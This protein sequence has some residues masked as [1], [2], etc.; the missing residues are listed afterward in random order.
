MDECEYGRRA[1]GHALRAERHVGAGDVRAA[2]LHYG[3]AVAYAERAR[4]SRGSIGSLGAVERAERVARDVARA[5][6]ETVRR[7]VTPERV[8]KLAGLAVAG[9]VG[10]ALLRSS[11]SVGETGG[12]VETRRDGFWEAPRAYLAGG[13][14]RAA[15]LPGLENLG[16]T[17]FMNAAVQCVISVPALR[18]LLEEA[19]CTG[20]AGD[21]VA[22]VRELGRAEGTVV[23]R[24]FLSAM[25]AE[26]KRGKCADLA[27]EGAQSDPNEFLMLLFAVIN[28]CMPEF[29][30]LRL[31][32]KRLQLQFTCSVCK[33]AP[34][35]REEL[36]YEHVLPVLGRPATLAECVDAYNHAHEDEELG[37]Y[38]CEFCN[39]KN[40]TYRVKRKHEVLEWPDV[41]VLQLKRYTN[42][43]QKVT[44]EVEFGEELEV[45]GGYRLT[46]LVAHTGATTKSG[47]Y[48]AV[49]R[50]RGGWY[51]FDDD[52][53]S[54][55]DGRFEKHYED[56]YLLFYEKRGQSANVG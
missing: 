37:E 6:K 46:G 45:G 36:I 26:A 3:R 8:H 21:F 30:D 19:S 7:E 4:G 22:L 31:L 11:A 47:H 9:A 53:V 10:L 50:A 20:L 23:P 34:D 39:D 16:N 29:G 32:R 33:S 54:Q 2:R 38:H 13:A 48:T 35:P 51:T 52:Q 14:P 25:R 17:C 24:T 42:Q 18:A 49:C 12:P 56:V 5:I 55:F 43:A 40:R 28:N 27:T 44:T 1:L 41:L 15:F